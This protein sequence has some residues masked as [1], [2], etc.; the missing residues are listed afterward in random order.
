M[1]HLSRIATLALGLAVASACRNDGPRPGVLCSFDI[2]SEDELAQKSLGNDTWMAVVSPSVDRNAMTRTGPLRDSCGRVAVDVGSDASFAC[3][4]VPL[5]TRAVAGDKVDLRD[6]VIAQVGNDRVILWAATDEL[7]DGEAIGTITLAQWTDKG[8]DVFAA[9]AV[10]GFRDGARVRLHHAGSVPVMV[11]E[12]DRC[13]A[14][15]KCTR[16]GQFV[17]ILAGSFREVGLHEVGKGCI[18]RAQFDLTRELEVK[19]DNRWLRRFRMTR[20]IDLVD[21]GIVLT[22][23]V[24]VEDRDAND[25]GLPPTPFRRATASRPLVFVDGHLELR[26]E[27]LWERVLRDYGSV[28]AQ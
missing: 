5:E 27:D 26:D 13:G 18:G 19:I 21:G 22:D 9:G 24:I 28:R 23:L 11:L 12:S 4:G 16:V 17:P 8:I 1:N 7:A 25:P 6:L 14:A 15:R 3:P 2:A 10:R 20:N